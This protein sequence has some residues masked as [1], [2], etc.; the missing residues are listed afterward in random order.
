MVVRFLAGISELGR[1]LPDA[2]RVFAIE[3]RSTCFS[4][5]EEGI[6]TLEVLHWLFESQNPSA[7]N[8]I[9]GSDCVSFK[10]VGA[11]LFDWYVLGYCINHSCCGWSLDIKVVEL[12]L[13]E[14]LP[15]ALNLVQDPCQLQ[16]TG[17]IKRMRLK[18][19][20]P[21][22][23]HWLLENVHHNLTHLDLQHTYLDSEVCNFLAAH[24]DLLQHLEY[25]DLSE[26][27]CIGRG[28]AVNLIISL[29]TFSTI[30]KLGLRMTSIGFEDCKA[31]SELLASSECIE[32][33][34]IGDNE[35]SP[36]SIQL[37]VDGLSLN[38]SL[39][40][41]IMSDAKFGSENVLSLASVLKG[42]TRLKELNIGE[43][44][45]QSSDSVHLAKAL[46]ENT[47]TQLQTLELM[48]NPIE[49][50]G[51]VA[52][53]DMLA[54]N[55]SLTNVNL[56]YCKI[57]GEGAVHLAEALENNS[58]VSGFNVASNPI[59]S[60][61][62]VA[63]ADM[64]ATNKSLTELNMRWCIIHGEGAVCLAK[65]LEKNSTVRE[66]N[67]SHNPIGSEGAVAFASMLK[68]NQCLETLMICGDDL[69]NVIGVEDALEL[70]ESL[71][72]NTTLEE[73]GL[74]YECETPSFS[75]L[76]KALQDRV[77]FS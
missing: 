15:K 52:F 10:Y 5:R 12:E 22:A 1:D 2:V 62:A 67:I 42:N 4:L 71:K 60:E 34:T 56:G 32:V 26:N 13:F 77:T 65:A 9:L 35:L 43:C 30:S 17:K 75:T 54:T 61:G 24:C 68:K 18:F 36:D 46:E 14:M 50:E 72:H 41:L 3:T 21:I 55:K 27:F 47:T 7:I 45:I 66:F 37:I 20:S 57:Q 8:R 38:T 49:S 63:F 19:S 6:V 16:T 48:G 40:I 28:G 73:L 31:L 59:G 74:S 29:T 44:D 39:E 69:G 58:T 53:A 64:L 51:A 11:L 33:L 70:I 76:D 23:V 25:L